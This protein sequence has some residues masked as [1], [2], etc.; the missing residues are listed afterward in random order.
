MSN[1]QTPN[2]PSHQSSAAPVVNQADTTK[3]TSLVG[4][5]PTDQ[6][7]TPPTAGQDKSSGNDLVSPNVNAPH[8]GV[9]LA[10]A[11]RPDFD[12]LDTTKKGV[13]TAADVKGNKWL[14]QSFTRCDSDHDGTSSR[15]E[16]AA[17][18]QQTR[19]E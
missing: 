11:A 18:K 14:S 9:K 19:L 10:S 7:A 1:A 12:N 15:E 8:S 17:C 16:C 13:L 6:T 2:P 3:G 4:R 5:T